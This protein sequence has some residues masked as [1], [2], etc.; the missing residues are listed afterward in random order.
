MPAALRETPAWND[1]LPVYRDRLMVWGGRYLSQTIDGDQ[2][3]LYYRLCLLYTS[4]C[5]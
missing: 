1:I 5:V 3:I 4:R 2:H